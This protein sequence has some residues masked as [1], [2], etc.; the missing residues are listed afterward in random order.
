MPPPHSF[1][2]V[3]QC[4]QC[5]ISASSIQCSSQTHWTKDIV[6][7]SKS[8]LVY[9]N[10]YLPS[11]DPP[12]PQVIDQVEGEGGDGDEGLAHQEVDLQLLV[13]LQCIQQAKLVQVMGGGGE[14]AHQLP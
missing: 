11:E 14:Q 5:H 10:K 12:A 1:Q 7:F 4:Q 9:H 3:G 6:I 13:L 8:L 2:L